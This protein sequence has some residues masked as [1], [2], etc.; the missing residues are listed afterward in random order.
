MRCKPMNTFRSLALFAPALLLAGCSTTYVSPVEVT[1][2]VGKNEA[3]LG[4]GTI[5]VVPAPGRTMDQLA[6]R[7]YVA[8]IEQE[9]A[10]LGYRIVDEGA[11]LQI[12]QVRI[13]RFVDQPQ[14]NGSPV[15]VGVGGST[16]SYGSGL[17]LGIGLDLSGKP[18]A[19]ISTKLG[20]TIKDKRNGEPL[21]EG[22]ADFVAEEKSEFANAGPA[23][24]KLAQ[25]IFKD[26]PGVSGETIEVK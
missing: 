20:I 14:K 4:Q 26:F 18:Q 22:R 13:E 24:T 1:R 17:G 10:A 19:R 23:A 3:Q 9:L 6:F 25:A 21:W 8:P 11:A 15:N 7:N 5:A 12:A 16:G 2:F